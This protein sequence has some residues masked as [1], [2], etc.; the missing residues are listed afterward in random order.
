MALSTATLRL[1]VE[2]TD[3]TDDPYYGH[4]P[5]NHAGQFRKKTVLTH[6]KSLAFSRRNYE[7]ANR[8][9]LLL[10]EYRSHF[11]RLLMEQCLHP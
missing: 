3:R 6:S 8:R 2:Q 9:H 10:G 5:E 1:T 11:V 4:D 7:P